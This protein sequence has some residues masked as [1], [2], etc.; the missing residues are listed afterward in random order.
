MRICQIEAYQVR[1][2]LVTP[3]QTSYGQLTEKAMDLL[4]VTDE[5]GQQG[6]GELVAFE[7]AN[8]IDQ[9]LGGERLVLSE[10]LI[11]LL[12]QQAITHPR[13]VS[14][15]FEPVRGHQ[16]AKSALETAVWDLYA[17]QQGVRLASLFEVTATDLAVGISLGMTE[18][19]PAL[20]TQVEAA[21][22]AGY[23]RVKLK[24]K[25]GNDFVPLQ[26]IRQ[27]FPQLTL[28]ADANSSYTL[29]DR[30]ALLA[31][32]TLGLAMIEQPFAVT[33]FVA[34]SYLQKE[35][36]TP[37]CLDE[38]IRSLDDV[39]TAWALGSCQSINLKIP[40][41]GGITEALAIC[42]FCQEHQLLVWLGG[43]FESGVG[44]SLNLQFASQDVFTFPGDISATSRYFVED[45]IEE[46]FQLSA[47]KLTLPQE[48]GLGIT[49]NSEVLA[50]RGKRVQ[51]YPKIR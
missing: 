18:D 33:D 16:M 9:T 27:A 20:L 2:P 32:D 49:L 11:P 17:K 24:I 38:N 1:L 7:Q 23:Q 39:K 30:P 47:G 46:A 34:H 51:L 21:V 45:V 10:E 41:V 48:P 28:M 5:E 19:V 44:R 43:M 12:T 25:P 35:L 29:E 36:L 40:R 50:R 37:L 26:A 13:E 14:Q 4:V 8:Y 42:D 15:L 31:L 3:F 22:S 6:I